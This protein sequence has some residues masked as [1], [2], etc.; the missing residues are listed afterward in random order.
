MPSAGSSSSAGRRWKSAS[1]WRSRTMT[2]RSPRRK[3]CSRPWRSATDEQRQIHDGPGAQSPKTIPLSPAAR[4][5]GLPCVCA[6][7]L[8]IPVQECLKLAR[9]CI[10]GEY[11]RFLPFLSRRL[12]FSGDRRWRTGPHGM[13]T[14]R[15]STARPRRCRLDV[16]HLLDS[17]DMVRIAP[18]SSAATP[19]VES[20]SRTDMATPTLPRY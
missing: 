13:S 4:A 20:A 6:A 18:S 2:T 14:S 3:I 16:R 5:L 8:R 19:P 15:L 9:K 17:C 12:P 10:D 1:S 7:Y 11:G